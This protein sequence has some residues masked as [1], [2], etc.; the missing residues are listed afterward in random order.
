[1][2]DVGL[3]VFGGIL[4]LNGQYGLALALIVLAI[5]SGAGAVVMALV[6]PSWYA[7]KRS[8]AGFETDYFNQ[9]KGIGGLIV[10]K[11]IIIA[12]LIWVAKFIAVK[13]GYL[14]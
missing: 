9:R 10:T 8:Q 1:M 14:T 2:I 11:A 12:I 3:A 5:I 7:N 13:A 4:Y 6:N